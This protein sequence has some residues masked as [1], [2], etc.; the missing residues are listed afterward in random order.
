MQHCR[1]GEW[2]QGPD[3]LCDFSNDRCRSSEL[4][5]IFRFTSCC[6]QEASRVSQNDGTS[7]RFVAEECG[8]RIFEKLLEPLF[9][10]RC[11]RWRWSDCSFTGRSLVFRL[12]CGDGECLGFEV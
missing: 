7:T 3:F 5:M 2:Q 9:A 6:E 11:W 1:F 8:H 4:V 10:A 12:R